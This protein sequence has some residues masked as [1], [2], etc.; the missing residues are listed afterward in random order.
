MKKTIV[1]GAS[2]NPER[3]SYIASV[4]LKNAG[5]EVVP[6][7]ISEGEIEDLQIITG[8]PNIENVDT[9]TLYV[10]AKNQSSYFDYILGLKP[11]RVIFNPGTENPEF[12]PLLTKNKIEH[13]EAC[14]LVMLSVDAF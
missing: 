5:F 4:R 1:L 8:M 13:L 9:I 11:K 6:V 7:G 14:T 12:Y 10:G 3:Y 2:T